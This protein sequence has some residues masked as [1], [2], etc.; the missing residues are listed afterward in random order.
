VLI[1]G[2]GRI[3]TRHLDALTSVEGAALAG[4]VDPDLDTAQRM[5]ERYG[6]DIVAAD[7]LRVFD[8][9]PID[10]VI[11]TAPTGLH[12][13]L[14]AEAIRHGKHVLVE[15]PFTQTS[16]EARALIGQADA[17]GVK[18]AS[19]QLLRFLPMF[20]WAREY[21]AGGALGDPV[22][23]VERR[24]TYRPEVFPWW[25]DVPN[26]LVAHWGSH[27]IDVLCDVLGAEPESIYC[28]GR[29][30]NADYGTNDFSLQVT[31]RGG[32]RF[33]S[34]MSFA[35]R[36][37]AH[38]IVLIGS[39]STLQF[40]CY[41]TVRCD[42][43]TVM[44]LPSKEMLAQGFAAQLRNFLSAED[45]SQLRSSARSVMSSLDIIDAAAESM[46]TRSV[47]QL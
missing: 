24:L 12:Y 18:L 45:G 30:V 27:S 31:M 43:T 13:S 20:E 42:G 33:G 6:G 16:A 5:Q 32:A 37:P 35:S 1:V 29:S 14:A 40:D 15:K 47:V 21:V 7:M 4:I 26:F 46:R 39:A 17:A 8:E 19:A 38:D 2:A 11:I 41:T 36:Y 3:A 10:H 34:H 22:Q 9:V 44:Q 25:K 23:A 28:Q